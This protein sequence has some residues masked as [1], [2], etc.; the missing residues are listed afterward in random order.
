MKVTFYGVRG[1]TPCASPQTV[2]YGGNTSAVVVSAPGA[3]P[4]LLDLGTGL[5][6]FGAG[7]PAQKPFSAAALVSHMHW[8][9]VQGLPFFSPL[10]R[11]GSSLD[12]YAPNPGGGRTI[13]EEFEQAIRPPFF[14]IYLCEFFGDFRFHEVGRSCFDLDSVRVMSRPVAHVGPTVGYR[15]EWEGRSVAYL[16]D[17]QQPLDGS[18]DVS[19]DVLDLVRGAD[20]LIH[21]AQYTQEEFASKRDWGHSTVEFAVAVAAQ[22][23]VA[24]LA[25]FHHD[26]SHSDDQLDCL[27][28]AATVLARQSGVEVLAA[29]E[30][31]TVALSPR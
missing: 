10:L 18:L 28:A 17:H 2:R 3:P 21:D 6:Y 30:G 23:G 12:V 16:P 1:S 7:L 13:E 27:A 20:L 19:E 25:L 31:L 5:R 4:I 15:L 14:P 29:H 22:G 9:H 8:D 24:T 11:P 26:P